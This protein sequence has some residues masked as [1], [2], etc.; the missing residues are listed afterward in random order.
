MAAQRLFAIPELAENVILRLP[1]KQIFVDQRVSTEW[2]D[3]IDSS[4]S[5]QQKL[6]LRSA[7]ESPPYVVIDPKRRS[8]QLAA[9]ECE[10]FPTRGDRR[11][12]TQVRQAV[13]AN[14]LFFMPGRERDVF[15]VVS[16][17]D[18]G[19]LEL[20]SA[21]VG[22]RLD[23]S[24][25]RTFITMPPVKNIVLSWPDADDWNNYRNLHRDIPGEDSIIEK[26]SNDSGVTIRDILAVIQDCQFGFEFDSDDDVREWG[27]ELVS[28]SNTI[29]VGSEIM[30]SLIRW[31]TYMT[32]G[33]ER[34][35]SDHI[36]R[37]QVLDH[38]APRELLNLRRVNTKFKNTIDNA[39][40]S[41][42][43]FCCAS[44]KPRYILIDKETGIL[45]SMGEKLVGLAKDRL[46]LQEQI[47]L[48]FKTT[49][50]M[51][52]ELVEI[53]NII[54]R[55]DMD[56]C[57]DMI[58]Q[59][60]QGFITLRPRQPIHDEPPSY[61]DRMRLTAPPSDSVVLGRRRSEGPY[62]GTWAHSRLA[63]PE[64]A[65][66]MFDN[67]LDMMRPCEQFPAGFEMLR[68]NG[69]VFP[70]SDDERKEIEQMPVLGYEDIVNRAYDIGLDFAG[71]ELPFLLD[72]DREGSTDYH[73]TFPISF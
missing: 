63:L 6:F 52:R 24:L 32:S 56:S 17:D 49:R 65:I 5:I 55:P 20:S 69:V 2:R 51:V 12:P 16:S 1:M 61:Y 36:W 58:T 4:P 18:H 47:N 11:P 8:I 14:P 13:V 42:M 53:N 62:R 25:A 67:L 73:A 3:T 54:L 37:Q 48:S 9:G 45:G 72:W 50:L 60:E 27:P 7:Q 19:V 44:R 23:S 10:G 41:K 21:W 57:W 38:L 66:L 26:I 30:D 33:V 46:S 64:R 59:A 70:T 29:E 22:A 15:R 31:S 40:H 71:F 43:F 35:L 39:L 28:I 34:V 68:I